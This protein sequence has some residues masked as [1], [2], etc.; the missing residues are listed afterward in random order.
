MCFFIIVRW[1]SAETCKINLM[2]QC[3]GCLLCSVAEIWFF[4]RKLTSFVLWCYVIGLLNRPQTNHK[5]PQTQ[6]RKEYCSDVS[7]RFFGGS[8]AW[9]PN[10]RLR[11][12]L[13]FTWTCDYHISKWVF[14]FICH[15]SFIALEWI[16]LRI[17]KALKKP[18]LNIADF[19]RDIFSTKL[20]NYQ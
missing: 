12:R 19:N 9:H 4:A 15:M 2:V 13:T 10:K 20:N 17:H 14:S 16:L 3:I 1:C 18:N 7:S 11:R 5:Q 6:Y 8:V